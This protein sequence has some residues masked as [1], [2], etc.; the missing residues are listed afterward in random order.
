MAGGFAEVNIPSLLNA[1]TQWDN[2][3]Y[4]NQADLT[5]RR[6]QWLDQQAEVAGSATQQLMMAYESE[7][8]NIDAE[9][10]KAGGEEWTKLPAAER[11]RARKN[12]FVR[13]NFEGLKTATDEL[14]RNNPYMRSAFKSAVGE[15]RDFRRLQEVRDKDGNPTGRYVVVVDNALTGSTGP[16][17][18]TKDGVNT[19][20][21]AK[22][23]GKMPAEVLP[24]MEGAD[25]MD[26]LV[27]LGESAIIGRGGVST[28]TLSSALN[29]ALDVNNAA[30]DANLASARITSEQ[31]AAMA[32]IAAEN[33]STLAVTDYG[34]G[35]GFGFGGASAGGG[36]GAPAPTAPVVQPA[37]G[38]VVFLP[39]GSRTS[40]QDKR[41][42]SFLQSLVD[43]V[44][45]SIGRGAQALG[46]VPAVGLTAGGELADMVVGPKRV[47]SH[48]SKV[49]AEN[50]LPSFSDLDYFA[51]ENMHRA[52]RGALAGHT[53]I[54]DKRKR[55][56]DYIEAST[57]D[58]RVIDAVM[59]RFDQLNAPTKSAPSRD[60]NRQPA[61]TVP[62]GVNAT[63]AQKGASSA[64]AVVSAAGSPE[65]QAME[66]MRVTRNYKPADIEKVANALA[67]AASDANRA[68][69]LTPAQSRLFGFM[70]KIGQAGY[71][72]EN[73]LNI[74][75]GKGASGAGKNANDAMTEVFKASLDSINAAPTMGIDTTIAQGKA[76]A[77]SV[78]L[79]TL[80][81][82]ARGG[83]GG[84]SS[85]KDYELI[86]AFG[87][88]AGHYGFSADNPDDLAA[89][90]QVFDQS[91]P[92]L[93]K[94]GISI[95]SD[96]AVMFVGRLVSQVL[97]SAK[98]QADSPLIFKGTVNIPALNIGAKL[99]EAVR[100]GQLG[101]VTP[102]A[103]SRANQ[104]TAAGG[105][106]STAT[107]GYPSD[108]QKKRFYADY[109]SG[110]LD[111]AIKQRV[112]ELQRSGAPDS[113][114]QLRALVATY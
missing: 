79:S 42:P 83:R 85:E 71:S 27:M 110:R 78:R 74:A 108:E 14:L 10:A 75:R 73:I 44:W 7:L 57:N 86:N 35:G 12:A 97:K 113:E 103:V 32:R 17:D 2:Q 105:Q 19:A 112:D 109:E 22:K 89:F 11:D 111:P 21:A 8:P 56:K 107:A 81:T 20:E 72:T 6:G 55:V 67:A 25:L 100:S 18:T 82:A 58:R 92:E 68:V 5:E 46:A 106:P 3:Q 48:I 33:K 77:E 102:E 84:G 76:A 63:T 30:Q 80:L 94:Y 28:K 36:G 40:A 53:S 49:F 59:A 93:E 51:D 99:A 98:S 90:T 65:K 15:H 34:L 101:P 9:L 13:K 23:S 114:A 95:N 62:S 88:V 69:A 1:F 60:A 91:I 50:K 24:P 61:V 52:A 38:Q 70:Q 104:V 66:T 39:S 16:L 4:A 45:Q 54:D 64:G 47:A 26:R 41:E 31:A 96:R 29:S 37:D 87:K 43:P